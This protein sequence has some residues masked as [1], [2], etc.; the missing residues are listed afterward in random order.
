[1]P[2][3]NRLSAISSLHAAQMD[4][5]NGEKVLTI[6]PDKRNVVLSDRK[7]N[8]RNTPSNSDD[9]IDSRDIIARIEELEDERESL[10]EAAEEV[11]NNIAELKASEQ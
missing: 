1:M 5:T 4:S 2:D 11:E 6:K 9:V 10:A 3:R 7:E 8:M